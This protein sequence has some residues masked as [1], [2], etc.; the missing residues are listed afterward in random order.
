MRVIAAAPALALLCACSAWVSDKR[1]R[2]GFYSRDTYEGCMRANYAKPERWEDF[3]EVDR[4]CVD[5]ASD[6]Y[7]NG[8]DSRVVCNTFG[9]TTVCN[10]HN[11]PPPA[12]MPKKKQ[13]EPAPALAAPAVTVQPS[14][15]ETPADPAAAERRERATADA[16]TA[17]PW[18][19]FE[20]TIGGLPTGW[21]ATTIDACRAEAGGLAKTDGARI[22]RDCQPQPLAAC[23]AATS[24]LQAKRQVDCFATFAGC[25]TYRAHLV[26]GTDYSEVSQCEATPTSWVSTSRA[27]VSPF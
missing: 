20:G 14:T 16:K 13:P 25:E 8:P 5:W 18:S 24:V 6:I 7:D 17:P 12:S 21:C 23:I 22:T 19:C 3:P 27:P 15:T 11:A 26:A 1:V 9:A 2:T 4:A 10:V